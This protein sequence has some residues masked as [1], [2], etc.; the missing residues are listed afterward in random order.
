MTNQGRMPAL[1]TD[2]DVRLEVCCG[3][4]Q[5][6]LAAAE[7]GAAQ[8]ELCS[9][10]SDGGLSPS[11]GL[12]R[13]ARSIFKGDINVLIRPKAGDFIYN[14]AEVEIMIDDIRMAIANGADGVVIGALTPDGDVD[15][16]IC[17]R[18]I[19]AAHEAWDYEG[20]RRCL[21]NITFHRA[22]DLARNLEEALEQIIDL[23]CNC[24]LT[25]GMASDAESGIPMLRHLV[26]LSYATPDHLRRRIMIMAGAGVTPDN[27]RRICHETGVRLIHSTARASYPSEMKFRRPGVSM[28]TP[29]TDEYMAKA[30]SPEI[31]RTLNRIIATI[32]VC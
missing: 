23:G 24:L 17:R 19:D 14:A 26:E 2:E 1:T 20:E 15:T 8:I 21:P 31:V 29:G 32:Q 6:V 16:V 12:M 13:Y 5:S 22:F 4:P 30:T 25:S 18:L 27:V 3:D 7:G 11:I 9:G 28:G 10:L